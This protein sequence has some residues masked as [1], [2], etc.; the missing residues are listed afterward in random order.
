MKLDIRALSIA[1]AIFCGGM[2]FLL[3]VANL[4]W[5]PYGRDWLDLFASVY[6]GYTPH[7]TARLPGP[8]LRG[9][10]I[11]SSEAGTVGG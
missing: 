6:P 3:G 1:G 10:I 9:S 11:D 4:V 2:F 7:S 5:P 8:C